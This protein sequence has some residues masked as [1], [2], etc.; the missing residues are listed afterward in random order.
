MDA[1]DT[2]FS[3]YVGHDALPISI[4]ALRI[5]LRPATANRLVIAAKWRELETAHDTYHPSISAL[6]YLDR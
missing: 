1:V 2:G 4:S 5:R 3:N 6:V